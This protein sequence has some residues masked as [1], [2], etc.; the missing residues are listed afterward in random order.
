[1]AAGSAKRRGGDRS[2]RRGLRLAA[3][4]ATRLASRRGDRRSVALVLTAC[5]GLGLALVATEAEAARLRVQARTRL[6]LALEQVEGRVEVHG[7]LRDSLGRGIKDATVV[8]SI[9]A[10]EEGNAVQSGQAEPQAGAEAA[11][12][13][14]G[15]GAFRHAVSRLLLPAGEQLRVGAVFAG[16][17]RLAGS[18]A[19]A[20]LTPGQAP[21]RLRLRVQPEAPAT[22][23]GTLTVEVDAAV[24]GVP[25]AGATAT[26]E[27]D[28][29]HAAL[30]HLDDAGSA[31]VALGPA[32][33]RR[34]G[35]RELRLVLPPTEQTAETTFTLTVPVT[36]ALRVELDA[37]GGAGEAVACADDRVC[38]RGRVLA[39]REGADPVPAPA[40]QVVLHGGGARLGEVTTDQEGRFAA[41]LRHDALQELFGPG[42][43]GLVAEAALD[44]P[45][46]APAFSPVIAV[47]VPPPTSPVALAYP[48]LL[49][50]LLLVLAVRAGRRAWLRR[51][52]ID[53][54]VQ[55]AAGVRLDALRPGTGHELDAVRGKVLDGEHGRPLAARV[56]LEAG[57]QV[58]RD[59]QT[60]DGAFE[61][62]A[63]PAGT[64]VLRVEAAGHQA[65]ALEVALPHDGALDGC[66]L[67]PTSLRAL[68]RHALSRRIAQATGRALDWARETPRSA[69]A[70]W[71]GARR[72]G[73]V[74]S[75]AAVQAT[76]VALYGP[77]ADDA[78]IGVA[79]QALQ[80]AD[81]A[82]S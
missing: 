2:P 26:L 62:R 7:H 13:T 81:E 61:W 12:R 74:A 64:F 37:L 65:L 50:A 34:P 33:W 43:L 49:A 75:R 21:V 1:M 39:W 8:V 66:T 48:S 47:D 38:L 16:D 73:H 19:S 68:L 4:A 22:D 71:L 25:V 63:V 23:D 54:E 79:E 32:L 55:I 52:G 46:C 70:R 31:A 9:R 51:R 30:L 5:A 77:R 15:E 17:P 60:A 14:G 41:H 20:Q 18:E 35:A 76:E 40:A 56:L 6:E 44:E 27:V 28:G 82:G 10:N 29:R 24:G 45:W 58:L 67:L 36:L 57:G 59:V 78:A 53:A 69:E 11:V 3:W 42:P 72:R 80:R